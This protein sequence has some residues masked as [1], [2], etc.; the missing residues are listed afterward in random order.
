MDFPLEKTN[1][2]YSLVKL[3]GHGSS[4]DTWNRYSEIKIFGTIGENASA[5]LSNVSV[6]P[7]PAKDVINVFVKEPPSESQLLRIFDLGGKLRFETRLDPELNNIQVPIRL[8]GGAYI[9]KVLSGS[10]IVF[11]KT[12]IVLK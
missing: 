6:Y 10:V 12:L 7:N 3:V 1:T 11:T 9:V 5:D 8:P 4:L 2:D